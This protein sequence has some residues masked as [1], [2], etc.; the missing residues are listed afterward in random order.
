MSS[1]DG[2][3]VAAIVDSLTFPVAEVLATSEL[4]EAAE[5]VVPVVKMVMAAVLAVGV[6]AVLISST[7]VEV[8]TITFGQHPTL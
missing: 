5:V 2:D 7:V 4:V 8:A 3:E 1:V 6:A